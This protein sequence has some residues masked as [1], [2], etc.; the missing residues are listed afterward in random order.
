MACS[1]SLWLS[2]KQGRGICSWVMIDFIFF[3][4]FW[5]VFNSNGEYLL[6]TKLMNENIEE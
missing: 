6:S 5:I 4:K 2:E 1:G 3:S